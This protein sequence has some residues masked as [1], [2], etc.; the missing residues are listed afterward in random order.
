MSQSSVNQPLFLALADPTRRQL[1]ETLAN[2]G[3]KTAT[4]LAKALPITRQ[5]V[6]KHLGL[7][8]EANLVQVR[9]QGRDKL[10]KLEPEP[11]AEA[12]AWINQIQSQWDKRL[13]SL[14]NY[15][16]QTHKE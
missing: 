11:L 10:Y 7:L 5:G 3:E 9:Q 14:A 12:T 8:L 6:S 16:D 13:Q 1:I 15:L 2:E 4:E